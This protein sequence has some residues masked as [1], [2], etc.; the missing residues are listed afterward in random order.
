LKSDI[1]LE[2]SGITDATK[3]KLSYGPIKKNSKRKDNRFCAYHIAL[4][5]GTLNVTSTPG[6]TR[7]GSTF[8]HRVTFNETG[9]TLVTLDNGYNFALHKTVDTLP[10]NIE[11]LNIPITDYKSEMKELNSKYGR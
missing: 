7:G 11:Y 3:I 6:K 1:D 10:K 2:L 4:D 8:T 5:K 9:I